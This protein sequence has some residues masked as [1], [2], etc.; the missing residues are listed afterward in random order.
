MANFLITSPGLLTE[1]STEAD[2]LEVAAAAASGA[3]V[4]GH[5]GDDKIKLSSDVTN[6][7]H[8][9]FR[10]NTGNDVIS[11]DGIDSLESANVFGGGQGNDTMLGGK[12][13]DTYIVDS[14]SDRVKE[15]KNEGTDLIQA[16]VSYTA[17]EHVESI[18]LKGSNKIDATGNDHN[19]RLT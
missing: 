11:A 13:N 18:E 17:P 1:G 12:G 9:N 3:T 5:G 7:S 4:F 2:L 19:N 15:S 16:S 8:S 10:G 14:V 6:I